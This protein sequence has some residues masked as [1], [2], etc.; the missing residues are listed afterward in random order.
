MKKMSALSMLVTILFSFSL[1]AQEAKA[2]SQ[3]Y[4]KMGD[5]Q[6]KKSLVALPALQFEG[7]PSST[8]NYQSLGAEIFRVIQ[9]DMMVSTYFQFISPTAFLED[10]SHK[11]IRPFPGDANG[12]KF[13]SWKQIGAEFLI[14]GSYTVSGNELSLEILTYHVPRTSVV[15]AKK[16]RG[17]VGNLRRIEIGRAHV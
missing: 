9:N 16:Y 14:R 11:S 10:A 7:N 2:G 13:E 15:L 3:I 8:S 4:I 5:A 17:N 12:F 6:T 1:Q